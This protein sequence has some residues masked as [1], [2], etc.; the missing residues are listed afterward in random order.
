VAV[1]EVKRPKFNGNIFNGHFST[2]AGVCSGVKAVA[3]GQN[4]K[5]KGFILVSEFLPGIISAP[6]KAVKWVK[7]KGPVS[8]LGH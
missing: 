4:Q 8:N 1:S 2:D 7:V 5:T 3:V 6:S